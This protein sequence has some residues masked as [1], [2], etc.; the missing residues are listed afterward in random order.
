MMKNALINRFLSL[1][2][3]SDVCSDQSEIG[4]QYSVYS[5]VD[6]GVPQGSVL[7]PILFLRTLWSAHCLIIAARRGVRL[8]AASYTADT[9]LYVH[10]TTDNCLACSLWSLDVRLTSC[11]NKIAVSMTS[12]GLKLNTG[13]NT[14]HLS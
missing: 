14:V 12:N 3:C 11:I 2:V 13:T 8:S 6:Y 1:N 7:G 9:Q 4:D 5:E 10:T